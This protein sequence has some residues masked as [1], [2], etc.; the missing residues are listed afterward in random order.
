MRTKSPNNRGG[1]RS[2]THASRHRLERLILL[3]VERCARRRTAARVSELA[4]FLQTNP[5]YL[6]RLA[7]VVLGRSLRTALVDQ[8]L[9]LAERL[10]RE[11]TLPI[12]EVAALSAF[13]TPVTFHRL[14]RK[15]FACTP[16]EYR[17]RVRN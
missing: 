11:T 4:L 14:F 13:G 5:S 3:Y 16:G 6:S 8:Q 7:P 1:T 9:F 17:R 15:A 2:A 12:A 10:L